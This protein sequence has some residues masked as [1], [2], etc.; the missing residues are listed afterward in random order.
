MGLTSKILRSM[1]SFKGK[2]RIGSFL[3][4]KSLYKESQVEFTGRNHI[5]YVLPNTIETVGRELFINGVYEYHTIEKIKSLL[6]ES[7]VFF[8]VGANLG[9]ICLPIAKAVSADIHVFEPSKLIFG[10]LANNVQKNNLKN[11][12]LNNNAVHSCDGKEIT[13]FEVEHKH[14]GSSLAATYNNQPNYLVKTISLD[15]YCERND[16]PSIDVLKIDVQGFEV[17]VLKGC[18]RLLNNKCIRNILFEFEGWAEINAGLDS[19][20]S[21]EYLWDNDYEIYTLKNKKLAQKLRSGSLMLWA[22]PN[23]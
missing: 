16:I 15:A 7:S 1:P 17:E 5:R 19:G 8:D 2:L 18:K 23:V 11:I 20:A 13:F 21:Q 3:L 22:R 14:G 10:Y 6:G 4:K 9:A 12:T